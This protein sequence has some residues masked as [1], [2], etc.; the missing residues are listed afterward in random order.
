MR[1]RVPVDEKIRIPRGRRV[2]PAGRKGGR[3]RCGRCCRRNRRRVKM[4]T[5][6]GDRTRRTAREIVE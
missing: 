1:I 6:E 3:E 5:P 2:V 4:P